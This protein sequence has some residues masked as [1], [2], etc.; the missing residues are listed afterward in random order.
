MSSL[1]DTSITADPNPSHNFKRKN[2]LGFNIVHSRAIQNLV[3]C[4]IVTKS[5]LIQGI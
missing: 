1:T 5:N 2:N 3:M 4:L